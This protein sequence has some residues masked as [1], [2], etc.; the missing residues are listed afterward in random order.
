MRGLSVGGRRAKQGAA[1]GAAGPSPGAGRRRWRPAVVRGPPGRKDR[2][3]GP[4]RGAAHKKKPPAKVD[5]D[6]ALRR[7]IERIRR[8]LYGL[9]GDLEYF[10]SSPVEHR[11]ALR[12]GLD[13]PDVGHITS[14]ARSLAEEDRFADWLRFNRCLGGPVF[15]RELA[16]EKSA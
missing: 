9:Y 13:W 12:R 4:Q 5:G 16:R 3:R 15:V 7:R 14:L 6:A 11:E 1:K 8:A 10:K 2:P